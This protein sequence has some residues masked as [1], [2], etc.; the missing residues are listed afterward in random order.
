[1]PVILPKGTGDKSKR[2]RTLLPV[3]P[4]R[5]VR[6]RYTDLLVREVDLL[7]A[8]TAN[9]SDIIKS[10]AGRARVAERLEQ[11]SMQS[12]ERMRVV[13]PRVAK[14]FVDDADRAQKKQLEKNISR[15]LGTDFATI[16]DTPSTAADIDLAVGWN[17]NLIKSIPAKHLDLVGQAVLD[18]YRGA[19]LPEGQTLVQRLQQIGGITE[20]RARFI[21]RDQTAKLTSALNKSRQQSNGISSYSWQNS[22]DGRVVGNPG[23]KYP[24]GSPGHMDHW[25]REGKIFRWDKPPP[26]GHPGEAFSCRCVSL[27]ILDLDELDAMYP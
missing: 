13:A 1:M 21:A 3:R 27:P 24:E 9:L 2:Q 14:A 22:G 25:S 19:P 18:N 12:I 26:D 10:D 15:A 11:L 17:A 7:K 6:K 8:Q 20:N 4:N 16:L 5:S 23:G